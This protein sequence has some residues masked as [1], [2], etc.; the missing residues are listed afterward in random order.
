MKLDIQ[1]IQPLIL[2][3]PASDIQVLIALAAKMDYGTQTIK[4]QS[5]A[6]HELAK[7]LGISY[8]ALSNAMSRLKRD[9]L[10]KGGPSIYEIPEEFIVYGT[11]KD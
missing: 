6:K 7:E 10:L 3:N 11:K 8:S 9:N 5:L 4:L 1:N 2:H